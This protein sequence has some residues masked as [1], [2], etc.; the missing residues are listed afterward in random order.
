MKLIILYYPKINCELGHLEIIVF[1]E[2]NKNC[3][4]YSAHVDNPRFLYECC[5]PDKAEA[6]IK[7]QQAEF[8]NN[9]LNIIKLE[10]E[11]VTFDTLAGWTERELNNKKYRFIGNNCSDLTLAVLRTC[12]FEMDLFRVD[13]CV[14]NVLANLACLV[15]LKGW[16]CFC[17]CCCYCFD[18]ALPISTTTPAEIFDVASHLHDVEWIYGGEEVS[19]LQSHPRSP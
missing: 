2:D 5:S 17:F 15:S 1:S 8:D 4:S 9:S 13:H 10:T 12:G 3:L 11:K 6:Y 16:V 19:L 7:K 14:T 18:D